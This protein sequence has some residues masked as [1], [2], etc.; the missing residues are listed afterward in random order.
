[1]G[2]G[3][4]MEL[5][6]DALDFLY[7][8][9]KKSIED[10]KLTE[11]VKSQIGE[12]LFVSGVEE[13]KIQTTV[14]KIADKCIG[15]LGM[16][17]FYD[18]RFDRCVRNM[19]VGSA[20]D[21]IVNATARFLQSATDGA[22]SSHEEALV[23]NQKILD[24][25]LKNYSHVAFLKN[26]LSAYA[27]NYIV[28]NDTRVYMYCEKNIYRGDYD[29]KQAFLAGVKAAR[30]NIESKFKADASKVEAKNDKAPIREQIVIDMSAADA[31]KVNAS[32]VDEPKVT[33]P[34]VEVNKPTKERIVV[35]EV[36]ENVGATQL[37]DKV[38]EPDAP[39]SS[40][41]KE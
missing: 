40:K 35:N 41:S 6:K 28:N 27:D 37:S 18:N 25:L 22:Y 24:V 8:E 21:F 30:E 15:S 13:S 12:I 4:S 38:K 26:D 29:K 2:S 32:Q 36:L 9:C 11:Y 5:K 17:S 19:T 7:N 23:V 3:K 10:P 14:D 31:P 16:L 20:S 1:M 33:A 34:K 39:V